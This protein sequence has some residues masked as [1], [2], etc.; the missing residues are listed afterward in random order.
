M[1]H[2]MPN[3]FGGGMA[4]MQAEGGVRRISNNSGDKNS[5]R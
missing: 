4:H 3:R 1:T 2:A 5:R